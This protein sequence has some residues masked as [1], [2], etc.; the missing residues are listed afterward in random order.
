MIPVPKPET[1]HDPSYLGWVRR[2]P[3]CACLKSG[4][5]VWGCD[6]A[7]VRTK[8]NHGDELVVALCRGHHTEQHTIGVKSFGRKYQVNLV[9]I[10]RGLRRWYLETQ[11]EAF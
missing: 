6:A 10:A 8:R 3:C 4:I 1:L 7:H 2:C 9:K 5:K 11:E